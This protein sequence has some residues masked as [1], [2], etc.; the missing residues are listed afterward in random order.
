MV[1]EMTYTIPKVAT[2]Q[3]LSGYGRCA[4]TVAIPILSAM[5]VQACPIPTAVLS[6]HMGGFGKPAYED[7]T[8]FVD[9]VI[10]HWETLGLE[11]QCL[12]SGFLGNTTQINQVIR[13][14]EVFKKENTFTVVDPVMGDHG[15][16]YSLYTNPMIDKMKALVAVAD[17]V[18]PNL[19]EA[20]FL[21]DKPY[22]EKVLSQEEIQE[23]VTQLGAMGPRYSIIKGVMVADGK[24]ANI[25]YDKNTQKMSVLTYDEV[26]AS[27]PGTGDAFASVLVGGLIKGKNLDESVRGAAS[28]VRR[29]VEVTYKAGTDVRAGILLEGI[30][31]ELM[32]K[33]MGKKEEQRCF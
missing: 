24:K 13:L 4:L 12:Y 11:F 21:L 30:L 33:S 6:T 20:Y 22:K 32:S 28:F 15:K 8:C 17:V 31:G 25:T 3:D 27:Y 23:M 19:T 5:G 1:R 9:S 26:P 16:L 29:A 14:F 18:T 7:L 10:N 2:I